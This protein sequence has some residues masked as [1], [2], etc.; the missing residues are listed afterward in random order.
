MATEVE[1]APRIT[2]VAVGATSPAAGRYRAGRERAARAQGF[3]A[4]PGLNLHDFGGKTIERLTFTNIYLGGAAKWS[5]DDG[6]VT[7]GLRV[8]GEAAEITVADQG[9][10]IAPEDRHRVF[11]RFYRAVSAR[12]MPGS[13]LGLAIVA[14]TAALHGGTV[15]AEAADGGGA[16]L[17]LRLPTDAP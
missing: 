1:T 11:K 13:G 3:P 16:L 2:S 14:Q 6:V 8:D 10:G 5:P 4:E 9:P 17:R 15:R 7:V 12:S